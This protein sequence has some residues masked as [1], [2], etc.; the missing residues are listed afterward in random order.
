MLLQ[1]PV[2][3]LQIPDPTAQ[4]SQQHRV[5]REAP[6]QR[7]HAVA[8]QCLLCLIRL[9]PRREAEP[10]D[11]IPLPGALLLGDQLV[12]EVFRQ[13][14]RQEYVLLQQA[15][16]PELPP[17]VRRKRPRLRNQLQPILIQK[18]AQRLHPQAACFV[19]FSAKD[20]FFAHLVHPFI[21]EH[22]PGWT[23]PVFYDKD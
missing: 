8:Q 7:R 23:R 6:P 21:D 14:S 2:D 10:Q 18:L 3:L 17:H 9:E 15:F 1:Q 16:L 19:L 4:G 13:I 22:R 12:A 5:P 20:R 11:Q